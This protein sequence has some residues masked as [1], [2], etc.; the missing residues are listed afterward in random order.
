MGKLNLTE[1]Q[2]KQIG[3]LEKSVA[4]KL[5][6]ILSADQMKTLME[7][8]PPRGPGNGPGNGQGNSGGPGNGGG[9]DP[10]LARLRVVRVA[11]EDRV[12]P[13]AVVRSSA[14]GSNAAENFISLG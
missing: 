6:T 12:D 1:D 10:A 3:D 14:R 11:L 2:K 8:R 9:G 13:A 5:A 7:T 4:D